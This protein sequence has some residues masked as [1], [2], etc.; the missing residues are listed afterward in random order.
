MNVSN[1]Y[2]RVISII[3][4]IWLSKK[5]CLVFIIPLLLR[6]EIALFSKSILRI[7]QQ[8]AYHSAICFIQVLYYFSWSAQYVLHILLGWFMRWEVNG[9]TATVLWG[10][11]SRT[12]LKQHAAF[13]CCS[14]LI[15]LSSCF[16]KVQVVQPIVVLI[17]L[18]VAR[19]QIFMMSTVYR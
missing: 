15:F 17:W 19:I 5:N 10:A 14:H 12:C 11:A 2:F 9:S 1:Q 16:I 18:Q 7:I 8:K 6:L 4:K 13:L 3:V